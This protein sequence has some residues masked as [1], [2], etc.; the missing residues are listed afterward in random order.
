MP[1]DAEGR[2]SLIRPGTFDHIGEISAQGRLDTTSDGS[3]LGQH[4]RSG[5]GVLPATRDTIAGKETI[6]DASL[7]RDRKADH[8]EPLKQKIN[9]LFFELWSFGSNALVSWCA[10][11]L[12]FLRFQKSGCSV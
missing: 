3:T 9:D 7:G 4:Q 5:L 6:V 10:T 1:G 11:G 2:L 12:K 8:K